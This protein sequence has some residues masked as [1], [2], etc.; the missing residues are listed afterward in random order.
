MLSLYLILKLRH[1][2]PVF[3][4]LGWVWPRTA[5]VILAPLLGVSLAAG[6]RVYLHLHGQSTPTRPLVEIMVLGLVLGP[7]LEESF[8][9]GCLFPVL[10][11]T[12]GRILAVVLTAL[13]FALFHSPANLAHWASFTGTGAA[14]GWIRLSSRSTTAPAF[15]HAAYNLALF[16][17]AK[18]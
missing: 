1:R 16:V 14:Y 8:F 3:R 15:A 4:P 6:V 10:A 13:L 9:R 7:I 12:V 5:Y 2:R 11:N 18:L 17:L